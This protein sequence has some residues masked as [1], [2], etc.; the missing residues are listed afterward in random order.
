MPTNMCYFCRFIE[1]LYK[2]TRISRS[3]TY[4]FLFNCVCDF[5]KFDVK[6]VSQLTWILSRFVF[7][8]NRSSEGKK[9]LY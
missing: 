7:Q 6:F 8:V 4:T 2:M 1:K 9:T 5:E 3:L